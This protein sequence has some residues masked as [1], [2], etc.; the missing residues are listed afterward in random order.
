MG[1]SHVFSVVLMLNSCCCLSEYTMT[2][3]LYKHY[4]FLN[5]L[6]VA[7]LL[8]GGGGGKAGGGG[9]G[10]INQRIQ[11]NTWVPKEITLQM[12]RKLFQIAANVYEANKKRSMVILGPQTIKAS[13]DVL[14]PVAPL[15]L[16]FPDEQSTPLGGKKSI[17]V[18]LP[19]LLDINEDWRTNTTFYF[20]KDEDILFDMS[21]ANYM[22]FVE[23]IHHILTYLRSVDNIKLAVGEPLPDCPKPIVLPTSVKDQLLLIYINDRPFKNRDGSQ[24]TR[25]APSVTLRVQKRPNESVYQQSRNSIILAGSNLFYFKF[26]QYVFLFCLV[27][28][29]FIIA[30]VMYLLHSYVFSSFF[31]GTHDNA[32]MRMFAEL[33]QFRA[34]YLNSWDELKQFV[35]DVDE[36]EAGRSNPPQHFIHSRSPPPAA[37]GGS[38]PMDTPQAG[39]SGMIGSFVPPQQSNPHA[40]EGLTSE[41]DDE[42]ATTVGQGVWTAQTSKKKVSFYCLY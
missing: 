16:L 31:S 29:Y 26:G 37:A 17:G 7:D 21:Y 41:D 15:N 6:D 39:S 2:N 38:I 42:H 22:R 20:L 19:N 36:E 14:W 24:V 13:P 35:M 30:S 4:F 5:Q 23:A 1:K 28:L 18:H 27:L 32:F 10:S 12:R 25:F 34:D 8:S 40:M 33:D 3:Y 9:N 11:V